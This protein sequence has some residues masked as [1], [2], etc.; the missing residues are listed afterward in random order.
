MTPPRPYGAPLQRRGIFGVNRSA[1]SPPSE[2]WQAQP[3][4]VVFSDAA[5]WDE[6]DR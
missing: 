4:G 6:V 5:Q 1:N 2:G 3:D